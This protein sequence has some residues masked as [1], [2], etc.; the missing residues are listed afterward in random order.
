MGRVGEVREDHD[1]RKIRSGD[2]SHLGGRS[3]TDSLDGEKS[4]G[5]GVA[6]D[7]PPALRF[8]KRVPR[9]DYFG[10]VALA[11]QIDDGGDRVASNH[12]VA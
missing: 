12:A 1:S 10:N 6:D 3:N 9:T 2:A 5:L 7:D 4:V 8:G 11:L